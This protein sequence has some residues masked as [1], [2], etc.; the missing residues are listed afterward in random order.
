MVT[1]PPQGGCCGVDCEQ[2]L[3]FLCKV[4]A[5]ETQ[6]RQ[7]RAINEGVFSR[8]VPL[9]SNITSWF[10][11]ALAEIRTRW[12]LREKAERSLGAERYECSPPCMGNSHVVPTFFWEAANAKALGTGFCPGSFAWKQRIKH[13][14][15]RRRN[16]EL[17]RRTS[18]IGKWFRSRRWK[19][20]GKRL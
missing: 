8:L 13:G 15:R 2:C 16:G 17:F 12:I 14:G 18:R 9:P 19:W 20:K 11:I 10:A 3:I 1:S 4:T 6:A 5:S 7:G